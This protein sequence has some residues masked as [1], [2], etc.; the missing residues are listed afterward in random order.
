VSL[1]RLVGIYSDP[2]RDPRVHSVCVVVAA[3]VQGT[4]QIQDAYEVVEARAFEPSTL[5]HM[6]LAYDHD[7]HL[8]DYFQRVTRLA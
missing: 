4:I 6:P 8:Q 3:S 2:D 1:K 5:E 7:Q